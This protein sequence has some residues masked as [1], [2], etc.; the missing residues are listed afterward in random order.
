VL[1]TVDE[2]GFML[3]GCFVE[4]SRLVVDVKGIVVEV[5][6]NGFEAY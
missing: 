5:D 3:K 4:L 2:S 1:C 6:E